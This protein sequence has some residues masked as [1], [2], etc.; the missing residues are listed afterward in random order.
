MD[1]LP[2]ISLPNPGEGVD[3]RSPPIELC[4]STLR[5]SGYFIHDKLRLCPLLSLFSVFSSGNLSFTSSCL[6]LVT[7]VA[8]ASLLHASKATPPLQV[9][10]LL[11]P[12]SLHT[13]TVGAA[14]AAGLTFI[15]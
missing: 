12:H 14:K 9:Q 4:R 6:A 7:V 11:I 15:R 1:T 10:L 3:A 13:P 8:L 2:V 5:P